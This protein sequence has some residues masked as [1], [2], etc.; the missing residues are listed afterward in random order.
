MTLTEVANTG[1]PFDYF[2]GVI[3][4]GF[5]LPHLF[6]IFLII[7]AISFIL[8]IIAKNISNTRAEIKNYRNIERKKRLGFKYNIRE[9]SIDILQQE[10][11]K[12]NRVNNLMLAF[13][14][15]W[16]LSMTGFF[17]LLLFGIAA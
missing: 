11:K 8:L 10:Q 16:I 13:K 3:Y 12:Q 7:S 6:T 14:I 5:P 15:V 17:F 4:F 9:F 1:D 2:L